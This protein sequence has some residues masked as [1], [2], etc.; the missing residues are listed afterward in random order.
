MPQQGT[1]H[2]GRRHIYILPTRQGLLYG[3]ILIAMLLGSIN[4]SLSLGFALTFLLGALGVVAMLHTWRNLAHLELTTGKL[5]PAFV[6]DQTQWELLLGNPEG[7]PRYAIGLNTAEIQHPQTLAHIDIGSHQRSS[8]I[9]PLHARQ[10]G[11]HPAGRLTVSTEFPLGLFYAWSYV[12]LGA[13]YL[14]YPQPAL[15][16]NPIPVAATSASDGSLQSTEGDEDFSGLRTY[17]PGDSP[18]RIDWKASAREQG[19]L[20]KQFFGSAQSTLWLDWNMASGDTE[21][22]LS[23]LT[24]WLLDARDAGLSYGLRLPQQEIA[25]DHGEQHDR[26]CLE[27][28]AVYGLSA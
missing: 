16:G 5:T 10:R 18:K 19:L 9:L 22:R 26:R 7:H 4:Y 3:L 28:L 8:V 25:I 12:D 20:T 11:W 15:V 2:L 17:Q 14:V 24:R 13:S 21:Q 1:A 27:T 6:G 23:Q